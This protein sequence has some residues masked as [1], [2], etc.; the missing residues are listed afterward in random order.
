MWS[1][2]AAVLFLAGA[3]A[4]PASASAHIRSV[5]VWWQPTAELTGH[6]VIADADGGH[7]RAL[8]DPGPGVQDRE[9]TVSPDGRHVLLERDFADGRVQIVLVNVRRGTERVLD[10]GCTDPCESDQQP[11]WLP[12]GRHIAFTRV[13]GPFDPVTGNAASA[14]VFSVNLHGGQLRRLS[15]RGIDG[16]YEDIGVRFAPDG[17]SA[18]V[19]RIR[20]ADFQ[21]AVFRLHL[22]GR[23]AT[24]LTDWSLGADQPDY[25]PARHGP[26]SGLVVFDTH[27]NGSGPF[28]DIAVVPSWC[29][30]L[31]TC[32]ASTR[33]LTNAAPS[34][35]DFGPAWTEDGRR[36]VFLEFGEGQQPD[37]WMINAD[38]SNRRRLTNTPEVEISP[39]SGRAA[40]RR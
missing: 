27:D 15:E 2:I 17:R 24:Q 37:L 32:T 7:A 19:A 30:P 22:N 31:S 16:I 1:R 13:Q 26:T 10:T 18:V 33:V 29:T 23:P 12:D 25:S 38:G 4:I 34:T 14:V 35:R 36:I 21:F 40:W 9:P 3:L 6:V 20:N 39:D 11:S 8:T 28:S 5:L